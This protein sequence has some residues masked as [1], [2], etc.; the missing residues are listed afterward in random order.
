MRATVSVAFLG[1][2]AAF[3]LWLVAAPDSTRAYSVSTLVSPGCHERITSEALRTVRLELPEAGPLPLTRN[4]RALVEDL[5]FTPDGDMRDLGG[6]TLLLGVRDNDLKGK[7]SSDLTYLAGVHGDPNTQQEH[8]LRNAGQ[9]EPGGSAAAVDACRAFIRGRIVEALDG[10]DASG[11]V[12][13]ASRTSLSVYLSLRGGV[14]ASLP[15]YYVRMGQAIHAVEDS[16][17]H[18]YRTPD[19]MKITV[20][21]NWVDEVGGHLDEARDGPGHSHAMD[22]CNDP[23][24]LRTTRRLLATDAATALLRATL[25]PLRSRDEKLATVDG[26]LDTYLSYS[27]GC[28]FDNNWC[29]APERAYKDPPQHPFGV[30]CSSGGGGLLAAFCALLAL[31]FLSRTKRTT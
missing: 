9:D 20:V 13:L 16:F 25:D 7:S 27:P 31:A 12:D 5:Q 21:L 6:A 3:L 24:E 14:D 19:G 15:T 23:D 4:E 1:A 26:V 17:T 30:G 8:C 10:L 22:V 28:T 18:T 11:A 29:D 2:A